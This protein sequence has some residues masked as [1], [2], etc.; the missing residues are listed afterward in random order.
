VSPS[1]NFTHVRHLTRNDGNNSTPKFLPTAFSHYPPSPSNRHEKAL[2]STSRSGGF[3]PRRPWLTVVNGDSDNRA[4]S[5]MIRRKSNLLLRFS[6]N[7][8]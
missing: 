7:L 5:N 3:D 4:I 8:S 1:G 6:I 2:A